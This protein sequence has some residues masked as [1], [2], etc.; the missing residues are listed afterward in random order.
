MKA[1][2]VRNLRPDWPILWLTSPSSATEAR[3]AILQNQGLSPDLLPMDRRLTFYRDGVREGLQIV[4][5]NDDVETLRRGVYYALRKAEEVGW[6]NVQIRWIEPQNPPDR[7]YTYQSI[8][9]LALMSLYR[10]TKYLVEPIPSVEEITIFAPESEAEKFL[11]K[12]LT[13]GRVVNRTRDWVNEP[14]N[15]MTALALAEHIQALGRAHNFRVEVWDK[16]RI[17]AEKMGGILAVN[18]GSI[19]PPTFTIAEYKPAHAR[20]KKPIVLVGKG[21]VFDTGGLS[22]KPTPDSMDYMKVDMAGGAV[23]ANVLAAAAELGLPY[24][25][26]ALVPATDNRPGENAYTPN[27]IIYISDGTPVEIRNTD[28]EGRLILADALVHARRYDPALA[29]DVATLTGAAALAVGPYASAFFT[30][31]G[32]FV[33]DGFLESG[34]RTYER[35]VEFPLWPEYGYLIR[36]DIAAIKNSAGREGGAITAA[37]FLEYFVRYPWAHLDIAGTAYYNKP[38]PP[39]RGFP[40]HYQVKHATGVGVRLILDFIERYGDRLG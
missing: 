19:L 5:P 30:N 36:S 35:L 26:I 20:N 38:L 7:A 10:F 22:L 23:V 6:K 34:F 17:E 33:R 24:H 25:L 31:A 16:T 4:L 15:V 29:I 14:P 8:G 11:E 27:D 1:Y 3:E 2:I 37:K 13:I 12:G 9:E 32:P 39:D 28:A 40:K 18:Q 21:L